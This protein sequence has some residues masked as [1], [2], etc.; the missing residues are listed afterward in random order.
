[1]SDMTGVFIKRES[2]D[3]DVHIP[4]V[5][6]VKMKAEIREMIL[7]NKECQRYK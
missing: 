5:H 2:L 3:T 4:G 7:Q 6:P 1:M